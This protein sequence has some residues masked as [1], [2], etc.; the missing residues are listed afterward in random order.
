VASLFQAW[1]VKVQDHQLVEGRA[2][3]FRL[4]PPGLLFDGFYYPLRPDCLRSFLAQIVFASN[5]SRVPNR[6][7]VGVGIGA[8]LE[9]RVRPPKDAVLVSFSL[10]ALWHVSS[11]VVGIACP[12]HGRLFVR[13]I[14]CS[15]QASTSAGRSR[16]AQ[17]RIRTH[18]NSFASIRR[19]TVHAEIPPSARPASAKVHAAIQD[20]S[21][22]SAGYGIGASVLGR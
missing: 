20:Q 4:W 18:G 21:W 6:S 10:F 15:I 17:P 11:P 12:A 1:A 16:R 13:V 14:F 19:R 5:L 3:R 9:R 2:I 22:P 7:P 8:P